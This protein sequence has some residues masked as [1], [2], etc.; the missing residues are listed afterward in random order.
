MDESFYVRTDKIICNENFISLLYKKESKVAFHGDV[1]SHV[2][3]NFIDECTVKKMQ[4]FICF[5]V[6]ENDTRLRNTVYKY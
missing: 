6:I 5:Y 1:L 4:Q 2:E 3:K